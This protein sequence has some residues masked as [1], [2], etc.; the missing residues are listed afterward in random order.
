MYNVRFGVI[1][2]GSAYVFSPIGGLNSPKSTNLA[3]IPLNLT[4]QTVITQNNIFSVDN[5]FNLCLELTGVIAAAT[6]VSV[7]VSV[8]TTSGTFVDLITLIINQSGF[9][10]PSSST[11]ALVINNDFPNTKNL[12]SVQVP[13]LLGLQVTIT[14]TTGSATGTLTISGVS[15]T[16]EVK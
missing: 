5:G 7:T 1:Q 15:N 10:A 8:A 12:I 4:P 13:G 2:Q 6:N 9:Q 3:K 16:V 11:A 14:A